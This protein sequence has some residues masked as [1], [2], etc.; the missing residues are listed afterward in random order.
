MKTRK[1]LILLL[2]LGVKMAGAQSVFYNYGYTIGFG[3]SLAKYTP[4][5]TNPP[6]DSSFSQPNMLTFGGTIGVTALLM[7]LGDEKSL[8]ITA[9]LNLSTTLEFLAGGSDFMSYYSFNTPI[10][11]QFNYGNFSST[12]SDMDYGFAV[13]AGP[14]FNYMFKLGD[15]NEFYLV[16]PI[17]SPNLMISPAVRLSFRWW[18]RSN[19]LSELN[20]TATQTPRM[21]I[22]NYAD[23]YSRRLFVATYVIYPTY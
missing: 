23:G 14:N 8:G 17:Y 20:F 3:K 1:I 16:E 12:T 15:D 21:E 11:A 9:D 13:G 22:G 2:V 18:S 7:P 5:G 4:V 6:S 10:L 19:K